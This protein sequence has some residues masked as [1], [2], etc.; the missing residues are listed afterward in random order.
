MS[1]PSVVASMA[2]V[3]TFVQIHVDTTTVLPAEFDDLRMSRP[4]APLSIVSAVAQALTSSGEL[5]WAVVPVGRDTSMPPELW[6][7]VGLVP[8]LMCAQYFAAA[9]PRCP[10]GPRG[11]RGPLGSELPLKSPGLIE[12]F[13]MSAEPTAP[14]LICFEP[15]LFA[16]SLIA[17]YDAPPSA[18]NSA[19][20]AITLA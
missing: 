7:T 15:T 3:V 1:K 13:L 17:A 6:S 16:G 9:A 10:C 18:R 2:P 20:V 12:W 14:S 5:T 8:P 4:P 19:S 11:P